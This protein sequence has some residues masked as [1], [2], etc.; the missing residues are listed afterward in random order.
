MRGYQAT[1]SRE[2][3]EPT[4]YLKLIQRYLSQAREL[5][6]LAGFDPK[7]YGSITAKRP[8]SPICCASWASACAAAAD[9]KWS[10]KL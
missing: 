5:E 2:G 8:T 4:E 9:R 6:K 10:W 1:G 7:P 3:L